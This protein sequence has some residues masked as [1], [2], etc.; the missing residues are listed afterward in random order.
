[1]VVYLTATAGL[2]SGVLC[3]L[4]RSYV[5][6]RGLLR[7]LQPAAPMDPLYHGEHPRSSH[8]LEK[9]HHQ[10]Q[11][12]FNAL[13]RLSN[14]TDG[15]QYSYA[16]DYFLVDTRSNIS[17]V[18]RLAA[19]WVHVVEPDSCSA[20]HST[21]LCGQGKSSGNS[22]NVKGNMIYNYCR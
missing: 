12:Y 3:R 4:R 16:R 7:V 10:K 20:L 5:R 22:S 9:R 19:V 1:M 11:R 21:D 13:H 17:G 15:V 8:G 2:Q 14:A 18:S 6:S